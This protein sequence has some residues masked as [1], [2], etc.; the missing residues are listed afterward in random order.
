[1]KWTKGRS[2]LASRR[3]RARRIIGYSR[4]DRLYPGSGE[5]VLCRS[6]ST[7]RLSAFSSRW[8]WSCVRHC[9]NIEVHESPRHRRPERLKARNTASAYAQSE[10][11]RVPAGS[12]P[13]ASLA[14]HEA[15]RRAEQSQ[16]H[17]FRGDTQPVQ[18]SGRMPAIF[19]SS[20]AALLQE[21]DGVIPLL[22]PAWR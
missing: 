4:S 17:N 13:V 12:E 21:Q 20:F 14:G 22:A 15:R 6:D 8:V 10:N 18:C 7:R 1:L 5:T 19:G 16:R 3:A 2:G 11:G 9:P